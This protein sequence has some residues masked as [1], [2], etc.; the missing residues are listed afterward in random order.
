MES[1]LNRPFL[2][3]PHP[4]P[5]TFRKLH[6]RWRLMCRSFICECGPREQRWGTREWKQGRREHSYRDASLSRLR[7]RVTDT[8]I[9]Q[10]LPKSPMKCISQSPTHL[11]SFGC[12]V[13]HT[14]ELHMWKVHYS[15]QASHTNPKEGNIRGAIRLHSGAGGSLCGVC[16]CSLG[17]NERGFEAMRYH[18]IILRF[19]LLGLLHFHREVSFAQ[20]VELWMLKLRDLH[21]LSLGCL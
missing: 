10:D 1:D 19:F 11:S 8:H 7:L 4:Y 16:H 12:E 2:E 17:W 6:L 13:S 20:R 21:C 3:E 15:W 18:V 9:L 5:E 14:S